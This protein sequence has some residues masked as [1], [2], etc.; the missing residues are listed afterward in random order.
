MQVQK[1]SLEDHIKDQEK[2]VNDHLNDLNKAT[3]E[4][5]KLE[6]DLSCL[7]AKTEEKEEEMLALNTEK[8]NLQDEV[9]RM[10]V[11]CSNV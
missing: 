5:K 3:E 1:S 8:G 7:R 10:F 2:K 11:A 4:I 9:I 6:L